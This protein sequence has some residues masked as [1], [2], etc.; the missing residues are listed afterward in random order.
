MTGVKKPRPVDAQNVTVASKPLP[1]M[2]ASTRS[3]PVGSY[4]LSSILSSLSP[5]G[6]PDYGELWNLLDTNGCL[7]NEARDAAKQ[8]LQELESSWPESYSDE[9]DE[10][11][12]DQ[13]WGQNHPDLPEHHRFVQSEADY[14][15]FRAGSLDDSD[16]LH[17]ECGAVRKAFKRVMETIS[18]L[19][20]KA[21]SIACTSAVGCDEAMANYANQAGTI[22]Q[23]VIARN[24]AMVSDMR[25]D[26]AVSI[27]KKVAALRDGYLEEIVNPPPPPRDEPEFEL[28]ELDA[29]CINGVW[30]H[31][32]SATA[33]WPT[34]GGDSASPGLMGVVSR[35]AKARAQECFRATLPR[36]GIAYGRA[37]DD[38]RSD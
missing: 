8:Q 9:L 10:W 17:S 34:Q 13:S 7:T 32:K 19:E 16:L 12:H 21:S 15:R 20:H 14:E 11:R 23:V 33:A 25:H 2:T 4:S 22:G 29:I 35:G 5:L 3:S 1:V 37:R 6:S 26:V 27:S 38:E 18:Y 36:G 24:S 30:L 28:V 31:A